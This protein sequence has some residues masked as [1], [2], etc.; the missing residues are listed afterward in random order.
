MTSGWGCPELAKRR[1]NAACADQDRPER[2]RTMAEV[3]DIENSRNW[4]SKTCHC[5]HMRTVM[6]R[7]LDYADAVERAGLSTINIT[8]ED[9]YEFLTDERVRAAFVKHF[10]QPTL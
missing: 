4:L 8:G 2:S 7:S 9:L 6:G 3:T 5:A 10:P 1:K